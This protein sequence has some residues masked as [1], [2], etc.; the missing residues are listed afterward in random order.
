MHRLP[1]KI[2]PKHDAGMLA[3]GELH[4]ARPASMVSATGSDRVQ[5]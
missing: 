1:V 4:G 3:S 2:K 5:T